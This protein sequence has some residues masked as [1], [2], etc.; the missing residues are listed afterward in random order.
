[1]ADRFEQIVTPF[2]EGAGGF[3]QK[4]KIVVDESVPEA[5]AITIFPV[6]P[7]PS[8]HEMVESLFTLNEVGAVPPNLT[9]VVP[10]KF[11]PFIT[12]VFP[13]DAVVGEK[14]FMIGVVRTLLGP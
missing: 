6:D 1:M 8:I 4:V 10:I 14:L 13:T 12:T 3:E 11:F 9:D 7:L 5:F 2:T